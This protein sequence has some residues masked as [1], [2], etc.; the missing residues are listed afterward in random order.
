V[1]PIDIC[2]KCQ[3][4]PSVI[5]YEYILMQGRNS[6]TLSTFIPERGVGGVGKGEGNGAY[7]VCVYDV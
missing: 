1:R 7:T 3:G 5:R 4:A 2:E 6:P